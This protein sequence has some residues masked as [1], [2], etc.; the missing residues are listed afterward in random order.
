MAGSPRKKR[1][2]DRE[3]E[4]EWNAAALAEIVA[5]LKKQGWQYCLIGGLAASYWGQPRSTKDVDIVL[6]TGIGDEERFIKP[7]TTAF[8]ARVAGADQFALTNR[9]I[10]LQTKKGVGIDVSLGALPF[11]EE[12]LRR[13]TVRE[14]LPGVRVR[15]ATPEDIVVMKSIANRPRDVD[16]IERIIAA[17]G[18][19]L[20]ADYIRHWLSDFSEF[21]SEIDLLDFFDRTV[22][23]VNERMKKT[24][25]GRPP[26]EEKTSR[27]D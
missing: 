18:K 21:L 19:K 20:D 7:L 10:L 9:V 27:G 12:M 15:I 8:A 11:E 13:A 24:P 22:A 16:D 2:S 4:R 17:Q 14:V 3:Q 1:K 25:R 23:S 5:F 6:L 26:R